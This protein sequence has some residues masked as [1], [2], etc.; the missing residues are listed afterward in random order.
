[1][2]NC[3]VAGFDGGGV[4]NA[5]TLV[6]ANG[7]VTG[8]WHVGIWKDGTLTIADSSVSGN[9]NGADFDGIGAG[10]HNT[11]TVTVNNSTVAGNRDYGVRGSGGIYN[12]GGFATLTNST[13]S[14]NDF[15]GAGSVFNDGTLAIANSTVSGGA[16]GDADVGNEGTATMLN[17]LIDGDGGGEITT[18]GHNIESPGDTCGL[19]T[20]KGDLVNVGA[21]DLKL[22]P[23]LDNGGPSETHALG[24]GSVAIDRIPA[25]ECVDADGEALTTDQR[26]EPRDSVCDVGAF[27]VQP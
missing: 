1:M 22:G 4:Y 11:G 10:I 5:G 20:N 24:A 27:E 6:F 17:R 13:V 16:D 23:L 7:L 9:A 14:G 18:I 26:G 25:E 19:D 12:A 8:N 21:D 3:T 15:G 2:T